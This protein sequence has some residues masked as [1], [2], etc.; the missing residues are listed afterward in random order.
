MV[1]LV[2]NEGVYYFSMI[3][4]NFLTFG[5]LI[6]EQTLKILSIKMDLKK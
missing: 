5:L 2:I 1:H 6:G 3:T 4:S